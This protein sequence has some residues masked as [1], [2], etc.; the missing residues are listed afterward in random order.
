[1]CVCVCMGVADECVSLGT[2]DP[3]NGFWFPTELFFSLFLF[4]IA[5]N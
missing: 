5:N 4:V 2:G 1:M 3:K